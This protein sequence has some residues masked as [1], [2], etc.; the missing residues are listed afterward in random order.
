[1]SLPEN[2]RSAE[3]NTLIR[4]AALSIDPRGRISTLAKKANVSANTIHRAIKIGRLTLG[5]ASAI[6]LAVGKDVLSRETLCP[7][8]FTK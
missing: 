8:R 3:L 2:D 7:D 4:T 6:E 1:M 5:L